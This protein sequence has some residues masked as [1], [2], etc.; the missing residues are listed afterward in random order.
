MKFGT[1]V[2]YG[3]EKIWLNLGSGHEYIPDIMNI[4]NLPIGRNCH[5]GF[6]C[7][8]PVTCDRRTQGH[9]I[10]HAMQYATKQYFW[11]KTI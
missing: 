6:E 4:V 10:Y 5:Y 9:S 11:T 8:H 2:D 7:R 1:Y 3:P